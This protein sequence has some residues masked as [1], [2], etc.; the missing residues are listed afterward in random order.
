MEL[1]QKLILK[2]DFLTHGLNGDDGLIRQHFRKAKLLKI[3]LKILFLQQRPR[4]HKPI[5]KP[6]RITYIRYTSRLMDWD[7]AS[8]SFKHIGDA[9]TAANIISDD[10]P[11]VVREFK[12][13]Q[14]KCKEAEQRTEIIIEPI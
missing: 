9:L 10:S 3:K 4:G 12:P 11:K 2:L 14:V 7:N 8:A 1:E 5:S 6:I 13:L